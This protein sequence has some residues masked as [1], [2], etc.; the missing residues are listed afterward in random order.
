MQGNESNKVLSGCFLYYYVANRIIVAINWKRY[1]L[2][3]YPLHIWI[4][5]GFRNF[6][7]F[8]S[9]RFCFLMVLIL[10]ENVL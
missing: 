9:I 4:V 7:E 2:C 8:L 5:V 6:E 1:H 3:T 10:N